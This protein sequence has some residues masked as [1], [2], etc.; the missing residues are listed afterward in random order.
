[1][2]HTRCS[3]LLLAMAIG[4]AASSDEMTPRKPPLTKEQER[5]RFHPRVLGMDPAPR[6]A[7]YARRLEMESASPLRGLRFRSVGPEVQGG[8]IV[9]VEGIARRPDA[10]VVAF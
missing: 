1:M 5:E 9:D 7:G 10:L 4:G 3:A 6:L 2:T 8:G